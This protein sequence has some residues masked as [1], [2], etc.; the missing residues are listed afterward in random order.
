MTNSEYNDKSELLK[1]L[2]N[3]WKFW[4]INGGKREKIE[5]LKEKVSKLHTEL[6]KAKR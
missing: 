6:I 3:Q 1:R 4:V 5:A 2:R